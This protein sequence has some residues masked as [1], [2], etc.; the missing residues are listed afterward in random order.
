MKNTVK[1]QGIQLGALKIGDIVLESEYSANEAIKMFFAG[2]D[3]VKEL[4]KDLPEMLLDLEGAFDTFEEIEDRQMEKAIEIQKEKARELFG[5][6]NSKANKEELLRHAEML[7]K[8]FAPKEECTIE[9]RLAELRAKRDA[10]HNIPKAKVKVMGPEGK[11]MNIDDLP[12]E[13]K[14]VIGDVIGRIERGEMR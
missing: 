9:E 6:L 3:F 7:Q 13:V 4:I 8:K 11:E 2:K 10:Q 1:L 12:E 5:L 14:A